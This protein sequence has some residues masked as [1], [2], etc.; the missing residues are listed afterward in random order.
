MTKRTL[1]DILGTEA[2]SGEKRPRSDAQPSRGSRGRDLALVGGAHEGASRMNRDLALWSPA[3]RSADADI[4]NDRDEATGRARDVL[5]NDAYVQAGERLHRDGVVGSMFML[6]AKPN[7]LALGI[8][9]EKWEEEFQEEVESKF[10]LWAESPDNWPDASRH[11]TLTGLVRLAVGVY[12]A[13]GEVLATAEYLRQSASRPYQT[14][15]QMIESDRL[16]NPYNSLPQGRL[17][18]GIERDYYGAPI[19]YWIRDAHPSDVATVNPMDASNWS[20]YPVRT[21]WGRQRVIHI[22]EQQRIDQT[23]GISDM[24]AALKEMRVTKKFR[25]I[26]LQ[27]AVVNATF[28]ASI[29]AELPS[30]AYEALGT[31][32]DDNLVTWA[33]NYLGA[34]NEYSGGSRS[35]SID[36]VRIP[37]LFPGQKLELRPAGKGGPLGTEFETSLLRYIAANL[38]VS[39]EELSRDTSQSNYSSLRAALNQTDKT[40]SSRKRMVADRFATTIYRLWFE[41]AV[42]KGVLETMKGRPDFYEGMNKDA[43]TQCEWLGVGRD[44][45]DELK[46]TQASVLK[47]NNNLSTLERELAKVHGADWRRVLKQRKREKEMLTEFDLLPADQDPNMQNALTGDARDSNQDKPAKKEKKKGPTDE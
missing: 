39:Y 34:V 10:N 25:D 27:N 33:E 26:I 17:R 18:G 44:Q 19:S 23:R 1:E 38:G 37:H 36:G 2:P 9:D 8:K 31:G 30:Q 12:L 16:S 11:N 5:R 13:S 41:E 46:E 3:L 42:G 24:V 28:A 29:E 45:I 32:D 40:M 43:F 4:L 20:N 22:L 15:I 14:A 7:A 47:I 35:L 21:A 6:S